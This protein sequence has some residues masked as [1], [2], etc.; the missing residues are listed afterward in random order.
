MGQ[1]APALTAFAHREEAP[2]RWWIVVAAISIVGGALRFH[3]IGEQPLWLD[4]S[5]SWW[6]ARQSLP[7]LLHALITID[8][9]PP[10]FYLLFKVWLGW[11][12]DSES[13]LR[14]FSALASTLAIPLYA[15]AA[16]KMT[17]PRIGIVA[18]FLLA[19]S[20]F[21]IQYA[22]EARMY[23]LLTLM[24]AFALVALAEIF[25]SPGA[26]DKRK[27]WL[28]LPLVEAGAMLTH[29]TAT[30]LVPVALNGAVFA[31]WLARRR[32]K[33]DAIAQQSFW[34][35]WLAIQGAALLLWAPWASGFVQ[36]VQSVESGFWIAPPD[37][38]AVW[39][40]LG[41][42]SFAHLPDWLPQR[43]YWAWFALILVAVGVWQWRR[44]VATSAFLLVLWLLPPL[45]ELLVSLRTPI[46]YDRT[47]IWTALPYYMLLARGMVWPRGHWRVVPRGWLAM[48]LAGLVM[49]S[50]LGVRNYYK[51]FEKE[52]W[53]RAAQ[54]LAG[55]AMSDDLVL[56][57]ASWA[58]LPFRYYYPADA[59]HVRFHG[60][61]ADLFNAGELEPPMTR[62]ALPRLHM[63][64]ENRDSV[65]LVYSHWWYTDPDGLLLDALNR[66]LDLVDEQRWPGI[67]I[68]HF[69]RF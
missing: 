22:Q 45:I 35:K 49:L 53:N 54:F 25:F 37:L 31:L 18:A 8:H 63:L 24:G 27:A 23:A 33:V 14:S 67:R 17:S 13:A 44:S 2:T 62:D 50:S 12:G 16:A 32:G 58:E 10:L 26:S 29:N 11:F 30:V 28:L 47:L 65:W 52:A 38:W 69:R 20:P 64:I 60:V 3:Q 39:T 40:T 19:I 57:H 6:M 42:L 21:Q 43:D 5:F 68:L 41:T 61:P 56:F 15:L 51:T 48:S 55:D 4:E 36:Q 7:E 46:F 66:Q 9:H 1:R 34:Y 59:P